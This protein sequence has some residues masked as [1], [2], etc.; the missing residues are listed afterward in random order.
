MHHF[1]LLELT[2]ITLC[3]TK[4]HLQNKRNFSK[5][6]RFSKDLGENIDVLKMK[7]LL[8]FSTLKNSCSLP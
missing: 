3:H 5:K 8:F 4:F 6:M 1:I 2:N 7:A